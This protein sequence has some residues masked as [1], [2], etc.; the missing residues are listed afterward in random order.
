MVAAQSHITS[1]FP[2]NPNV[3]R[4]ESTI[5]PFS[6][7]R[8]AY[9]SGSLNSLRKQRAKHGGNLQQVDLVDIRI[10]GT[11]R[12]DELLQLEEAVTRLANVWP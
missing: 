1:R 12:D 5:D 4:D 9:G 10:A 3:F 7:F 2:E 11:A 8:F 6:H